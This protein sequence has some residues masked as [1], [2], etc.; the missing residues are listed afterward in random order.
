MLAS[1]LINSNN[2]SNL[3]KVFNSYEKNASSHNSFE[4]I[5]N[6]DDDDNETKQYLEEQIKKRK[7]IIKYIESYEGDYFSGHINNNK[8]LSHVDESAYFI[9]CNVEIEFLIETKNWD[10]KL[11]EY[12]N[13]FEDGIFRIR[14]SSHKLRSY[15]DFWECCFAPVK[16]NFYN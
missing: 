6:I 13:F 15:F 9:S 10:K 16:Y 14:C 1:I 4:F 7:F 5:I 3:E 2:K 11:E 12:K 8:M